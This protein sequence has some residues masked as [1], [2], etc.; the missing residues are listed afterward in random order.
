MARNYSVSESS[1]KLPIKTVAGLRYSGPYGSGD[2]AMDEQTLAGKALFTAFSQSKERKAGEYGNTLF[3]DKLFNAQNKANELA[4]SKDWK[5]GNYLDNQGPEFDKAVSDFLNSKMGAQFVNK[6]GDK[7]KDELQKAIAA[8]SNITLGK[9]D[10]VKAVSSVFFP[11]DF[12][13]QESTSPKL[14]MAGELQI[15]ATAAKGKNSTT[16]GAELEIRVFKHTKD[17]TIFSRSKTQG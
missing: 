1:E 6:F 5:K 15:V 14:K 13:E 3:N 17:G 16:S 2:P 4:A 7:A 11:I 8:A 12:V 10:G 9:S